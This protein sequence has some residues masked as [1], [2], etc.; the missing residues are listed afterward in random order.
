MQT[1]TY[2]LDIGEPAVAV[3]VAVAAPAYTHTSVDGA[4]CDSNLAGEILTDCRGTCMHDVAVLQERAAIGTRCDG[5]TD[6]D[7][8]LHEISARRAESRAAKWSWLTI[9]FFCM[10]LFVFC[11]LLVS[12]GLV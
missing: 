7:I 9:F 3:A 10:G 12:L 11:S 8:S 6:H 5:S 2:L 1:S 4:A